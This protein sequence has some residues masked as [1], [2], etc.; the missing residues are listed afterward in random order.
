ME[1]V[2]TVIGVVHPESGNW[3]HEPWKATASDG[4]DIEITLTASA[5]SMRIATEGP[6]DIDAAIADGSFL[7]WVNEVVYGHQP[8]LRLLLDSLGLHLGGALDPEMKGGMV[9]GVASVHF[10][11]TLAEFGTVAGASAV[12]R[13]TLFPTALMAMENHFA[14]SAIADM[15][16]ALRFDPD[17]L[18]FC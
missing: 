7:T 11:T 9:E 16:H 1:R 8:L 3:W 2:V 12:G 5:Y 15:R 18:F 13:E 17:C 10:M 14:R 6:D 4:S